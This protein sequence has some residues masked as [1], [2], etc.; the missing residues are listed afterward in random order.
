VGRFD[1]GRI[2][3]RVPGVLAGG[4]FVYSGLLKVADPGRFLLDLESFPFLP[5]V[6]AFATALVLPWMELLGG[7]ALIVGKLKEGGRWLLVILTGAFLAFIA[8]AASMGID[9]DC[10]CFGDYWV[11]PNW[12][13]HALFNLGLLILLLIEPILEK[14]KL[15]SP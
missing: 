6:L 9:A 2:L 8:V 4:L 3:R 1:S 5:S 13:V 11:F 14:Q 15:S 7:A 10:G 12:G